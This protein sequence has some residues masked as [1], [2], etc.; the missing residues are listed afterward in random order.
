MAVEQHRHYKKWRDAFERLIAAKER[1]DEADESNRQARL[2]DYNKAI[3]EYTKVI[4]Y[5]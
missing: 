2:L 5:L 1:L 3:V 4:E